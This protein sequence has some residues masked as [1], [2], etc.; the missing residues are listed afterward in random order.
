[1]TFDS[2]EHGTGPYIYMDD[3]RW[4]PFGYGV[5]DLGPGLHYV[6]LRARLGTG[7]YYVDFDGIRVFP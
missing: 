5:V 3:P 1:M 6:E 2:A 7:E 4:R